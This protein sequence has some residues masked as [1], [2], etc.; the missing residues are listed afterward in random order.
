M[1]KIITGILIILSINCFSQSLDTVSVSLTLRAQ[2]WAWLVGKYGAGQD[3]ASKVKIRAIRT[4]MIAANPATWTTNV[5]INN[6]PGNIVIWAYNQYNQAGFGE[7]VNMGTTNAERMTIYT[8]IRAITNSAVQYFI[9]VVDGNFS[10][11]FI[12]TRQQ[13][14][15][16]LLDN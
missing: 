13:G 14:K 11:Q 4:A 10:N 2:D 7:I 8:T 12:N 1:K 5:T 3:S 15:Q 16:I 9:G 6:I